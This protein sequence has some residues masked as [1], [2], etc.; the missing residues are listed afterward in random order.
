M[1]KPTPPA[2]WYVC[3]LSGRE[4]WVSTHLRKNDGSVVPQI[5]R[6]DVQRGILHE[7]KAL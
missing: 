3:T 1:E 6:R 5:H 4:Y 7:H 2:R